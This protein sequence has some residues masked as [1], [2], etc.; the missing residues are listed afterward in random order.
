MEEQGMP[1]LS[2]FEVKEREF[3]QLLLLAQAYNQQHPERE[4]GQLETNSS[5][6]RE[7]QHGSNENSVAERKALRDRLAITSNENR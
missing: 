2:S 7:N 3:E 6:P 1:E 4:R 5:D